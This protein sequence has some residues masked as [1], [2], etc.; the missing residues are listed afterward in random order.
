MHRESPKLLEDIRQA[1]D[2]IARVTRGK[3]LQLY[4]EDELLRAAVERKFLIIGEALNRLQKVDPALAADLPD[5]PQII[6][7]RNILVHGYDVVSDA[8]VWVIIEQDVP[9]LLQ[10]VA[11]RLPSE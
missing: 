11:Q 1:C 4:Q 10:R 8:R 3:S 6:A 2:F 7:F 5:V 9:V